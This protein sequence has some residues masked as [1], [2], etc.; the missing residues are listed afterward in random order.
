MEAT[1][2]KP[3]IKVAA[4]CGSLREASYH[5]GLVNSE[6]LPF[7]NEDLEVDGT[8]PPVVEAFCQKILEADSV[9][10]ASPE[11]QSI[12]ITVSVEYHRRL[13]YE[14]PL[15]LDYNLFLSITKYIHL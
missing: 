3:L 6:H 7:E 11:G 5:R 4:L 9:L 14:T 12:N 1:V 10:F 15:I 2:A 8:Y 13:I